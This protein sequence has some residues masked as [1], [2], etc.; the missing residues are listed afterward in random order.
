MTALV[1]GEL[2]KLWTTR[3]LALLTVLSVA[4]A[5]LQMVGLIISGG[6]FDTLGGIDP[7]EFASFGASAYIFTGTLGVISIANEGRHHT[8]DHTY[9]ATPRRS[10]VLVAKIA[11]T[12]LT[13]VFV[14]LVTEAAIFGAGL[15]WLAAKGVNLHFAASVYGDIAGQVVGIAFIGILGVAVGAIIRS[16]V[17]GILLISMWLFLAES[18]L[19]AIFPSAGQFFPARGLLAGLAGF[20]MNFPRWEIGVL[21]LAYLAFFGGVASSLIETRDV[22]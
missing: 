2:L 22:S 13:S 4:L 10:R 15:P 9:L 6:R 17:A 8:A 20:T 21:M 14:G 1:R 12:A 11:A 3:A 5:V 18:F 7:R 16:Q 19:Y